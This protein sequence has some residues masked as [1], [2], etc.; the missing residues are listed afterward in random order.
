MHAS[1]AKWR[2]ADW[3]LVSRIYRQ[4]GLSILLVGFLF[5]ISAETVLG[6]F[7][8]ASKLEPAIFTTISLHFCQSEMVLWRSKMPSLPAVKRA[9]RAAWVSIIGGGVFFFLSLLS[10]VASCVSVYILRISIEIGW[11]VVSV[12]VIQL[13]LHPGRKSIIHSEKPS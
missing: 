2:K 4:G 3:L 13:L 11:T 7:L 10:R 9:C 5:L 12:L 6:I 8:V 1:A